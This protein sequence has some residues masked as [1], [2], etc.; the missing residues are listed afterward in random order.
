MC[1]D[2]VY[3]PF[4]TTV[5]GSTGIG[6]SHLS[7]T[8]DQIEAIEVIEIDPF[9][10]HRPLNLIVKINAGSRSNGPARQSMVVEELS[11]FLVERREI[12]VLRCCIAW[13]IWSETAIISGF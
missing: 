9:W 13:L 7:H 2:S 8:R 6:K 3:K 4:A 1:L 5:K 11:T 10:S 12:I